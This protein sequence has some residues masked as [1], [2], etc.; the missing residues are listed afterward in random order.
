MTRLEYFEK[1]GTV[2]LELDIIP[3]GKF[4]RFIRFQVYRNH[5]NTGKTPAEAVKLTADECCCTNLRVYR[6]IEFFK[7]RIK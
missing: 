4:R 6:A 3:E 5:V 1:Y 7:K 2:G